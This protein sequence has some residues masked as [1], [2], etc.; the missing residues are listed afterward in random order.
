MLTR[1]RLVVLS[2]AN[3]SRP[4]RCTRGAAAYA[5]SRKNDVR[6]DQRQ[7]LTRVRRLGPTAGLRRIP[8]MVGRTHDGARHL[9]TETDTGQPM[10]GAPAGDDGKGFEVV[11]VPGKGK[12]VV[13]TRLLPA[14]HQL[15]A[16]A[17]LVSHPKAAVRGEVCDRCL[18][19]LDTVSR[20]SGETGVRAWKAVQ[21]PGD[22][23]TDCELFCSESC[24]STAFSEYGQSLV[25]DNST[26][27]MSSFRTE[28]CE[29]RSPSVIYPLLAARLIGSTLQEVRGGVPMQRSV[30]A[31]ALSL[32]GMR[33]P[34]PP[35]A[36]AE[37][38]TGLA[39]AL[40]PGDNPNRG[41][42]SLEW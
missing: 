35:P 13:A 32:V 34:N 28:G 25:V 39:E 26:G 17:P 36:W 12:G 42:F 38:Y 22:G 18:K 15:W 6:G 16:E 11:D 3:A 40:M 30:A 23:D 29:A 33:L 37:Q 14:G 10:D 21:L 8:L 20:S 1:G 7:N 5:C 27:A 2:A 41:V 31:T 19:R 24:A 9:A 4:R